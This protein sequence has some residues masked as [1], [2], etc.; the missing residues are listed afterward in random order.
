[1]KRSLI[2]LALTAMV[3][4]AGVG[5]WQSNTGAKDASNA[6]VP[7][8]SNP[9]GQAPSDRELLEQQATQQAEQREK[10][11]AELEVERSALSAS[12]RELAETQITQQDL[13]HGNFDFD[14]RDLK[15]GIDPPTATE[16]D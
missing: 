3:A 1:M 10:A 5:V 2:A 15:R 8:V 4:V 12:L 11:L 6:P 13:A 16:P 9:V 14:H 7:G